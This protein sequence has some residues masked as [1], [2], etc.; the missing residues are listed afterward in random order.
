M[1][2]LYCNM[3]RIKDVL[4]QKGLKQVWLAEQLGKSFRIVNSYA[5]NRR[6]PNLTEL[7]RIA[8]VLGVDPKDLLVDINTK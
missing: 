4:K 2:N 1:V 7:Y 8:H 5:C 3:N 6:Q